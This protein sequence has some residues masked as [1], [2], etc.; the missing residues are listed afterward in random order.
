MEFNKGDVVMTPQGIGTV[1]FKR[2]Q[3]PTYATV[4]VYSVCLDSRKAESES[5]SGTIYKAYQVESL[6]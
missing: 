2:M 3:A 6:P 1:V 5:Y 4:D